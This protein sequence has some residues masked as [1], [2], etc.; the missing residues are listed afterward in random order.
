ML[1]VFMEEIS[2]AEQQ[3]DV[4][5][6]DAPQRD[7]SR[8]TLTIKQA[9]DLLA[10][11]GVPR[12]PRSVQ[13]FCELG[14]IDCL[15]VKGEKTERYFIDPL[16][17]ERYAQ[18]LRQLENISQIGSD[19]TRHDASQRDMAR[20]D[21][22]E[23]DV[24]VVPK[25][26]AEP[27][28]ETAEL[29]ARIDIL[30]KE[31]GQL[32]IDLAARVIVINQMVDERRGFVTQLTELS[33]ENGRLEMQVQQLAAPRTARHDAPDGEEQ[34]REGAEADAEPAEPERKRSLFG[35]MFGR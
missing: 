33:R 6:H 25:P 29:S 23:A 16:S 32:Q 28:R 11:F 2:A 34:G 9:A 20:H 26:V 4:T 27:S 1:A 30:Q 12:A 35:R 31:K 8:H 7:M 3:N 15:R 10:S 24:V 22:T 14:S 21:A 13:R 17:V 18:E 19:V 5:R